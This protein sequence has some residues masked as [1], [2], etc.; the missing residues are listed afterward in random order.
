MC[1]VTAMYRCYI[2]DYFGPAKH[3]TTKDVTVCKECEKVTNIVR[4]D[5]ENDDA[6]KA[7][8]QG[9]HPWNYTEHK[10]LTMKKQG[11]EKKLE[12]TPLDKVT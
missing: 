11:V 3:F 12:D 9:V 6:S 8:E 10:Y 7:K 4:N 1:V 2:C 5:Y